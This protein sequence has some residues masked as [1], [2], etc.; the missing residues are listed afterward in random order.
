M[1]PKPKSEDVA[2]LID[3]VIRDRRLAL[4]LK[5]QQDDQRRALPRRIAAVDRRSVDPFEDEWDNL[6][7]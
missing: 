4:L 5:R 3:R 1:P 7:V 6:P 2:D